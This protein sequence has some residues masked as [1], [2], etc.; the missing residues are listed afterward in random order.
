MSDQPVE[1]APVETAPV[2]ETKPLETQPEVTQSAESKPE[3]KTEETKEVVYQFK[4]PEGFELNPEYTKGLESYA[5]ENGL[6]P[7]QA[8]AALNRETSMLQRIQESQRQAHE[9]LTTETWVNEIENDPKIGG[10]AFKE[11]MEHAFR[12]MKK[13]GT[14]ELLKELEDTGYGNHPGLVRM[15]VGIGKAMSNDGFIQGK[16]SSVNHEPVEHRL[17]PSMRKN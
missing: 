8:Q 9:K 2:E 16:A 13:F 5:R 10:I 15:M 3:Q 6:S 4:G 7:E 14:P 17:Y 11:N 1:T 12:A